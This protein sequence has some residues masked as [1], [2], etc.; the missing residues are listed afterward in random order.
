MRPSN[1]ASGALIVA[2][3]ACGDALD[4]DRCLD[5]GGSFDYVARRC[6]FAL[7]HPGPT[8]GTAE[9]PS[10]LTGKFSAVSESEWTLDLSLEAEGLAVID[11]S[12]WGGA[13]DYSKTET[14][15]TTGTWRAV[16]DVVTV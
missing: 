11:R 7:S 9:R 8:D 14:D 2:L 1:V 12:W 16:G 5:S 4:V 3:A 6:D 13:D 10:H 15:R